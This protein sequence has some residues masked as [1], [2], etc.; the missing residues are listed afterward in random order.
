MSC[1]LALTNES[2]PKEHSIGIDSRFTQ[3]C[4]VALYVNADLCSLLAATIQNSVV[5]GQKMQ[6]TG[7]HD[8][9]EMRNDATCGETKTSKVLTQVNLLLF[10]ILC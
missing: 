4:N 3:Q 8:G 10:P 1:A 5:I 6:L 2:V 9:N 7:C